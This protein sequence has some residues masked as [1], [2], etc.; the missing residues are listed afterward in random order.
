MGNVNCLVG[1]REVFKWILFQKVCTITY[2]VSLNYTMHQKWKNLINVE[3]PSS[4]LLRFT[5]LMKN[6]G[7]MQ[8][9]F[10]LDE[11]QVFLNKMNET[12]LTK[13]NGRNAKAVT[14]QLYDFI[15]IKQLRR[16]IYSCKLAFKLLLE[17]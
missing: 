7:R 10:I 15:C 3:N 6:K 16:M 4:N 13:K 5:K 8:V 2:L 11:T 9:H 12:N 1:N 14:P 17:L